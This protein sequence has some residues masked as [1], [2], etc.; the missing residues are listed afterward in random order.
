M[1]VKHV[2]ALALGIAV[3]ATG[4]CTAPRSV[5]QP[6][7]IETGSGAAVAEVWTCPMHAQ[8]RLPEFGPCPICEMDLVRLDAAAEAAGGAGTV[9]LSPAARE[10]ARIVT[11]PVERHALKRSVRMVGKIAYDESSIRTIAAWVPGRLD[12]LFVDYTGVRVQAGDHLVSL[13]SPELV[14]AQEELLAARG[15]R[16]ATAGEES[17]FLADSNDRAYASTREKLLLLGLTEAQVVALE[18][19]GAVE[20]HVELTSPGSGVVIEKLVNEGAYVETGTVIY[21][22]ADLGRLWI[23]LDA[24]EQDLAWLRIGQRVEM[25]PEALPG[26]LIEGRIAFIDPSIDE[27]TRTA[28]VRV[29]VVNDRER[30]KPGMFVRAVVTA[31]LGA[32]GT[33]VESSLEGKWISP[34]HPEVVKDG[35]GA[36]D[37]CGMDLVPAEELG[38]APDGDPLGALPL[39]VPASAVL[40]TGRRA[41]V[42]VE[43]EGAEDPTYAGREIVLGTRARDEYVVLAGLSEGERVV[44]NGAFR[45]D[46]AMQIEAKPSMMSMPAEVDARRAAGAPVRAA[47][48]PAFERYL[49]LQSAL[50][51]D[52][53]GDARDAFAALADALPPAVEAAGAELEPT[54]A[55]RARWAAALERLRAAASAEAPDIDA[56]RIVFRTLSEALIELE[57]RFGH[58]GAEPYV[59]VEC[60]MAFG[61]QAAAWLQRPGDVH[62]PYQ[63][64]R[65]Q[66]C[67]SVER[68]SLGADDQ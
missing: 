33:L 24:Y 63:G 14:A 53:W 26:E 17:A 25:R 43:V 19:R 28:K 46:S 44:V 2:L 35:P 10:L 22:V 13:Y 1:E 61:D 41:V 27:R 8:V 42:Y 20:D 47:L 59:E 68:T 32:G 65:M 56:L 31:E 23:Q 15:L 66:Q 11:A 52:A 34:M 12:R 5:A 37:V 64:L 36:C 18:T 38:W 49:A 4:R 57:A 9:R 51:D 3:F 55:E 7:A 39:V 45:I 60:P 29:N 62:N 21:R 40:L 16:A 54:D 58:A 48:A 67:G 50:G 6:S 30:L